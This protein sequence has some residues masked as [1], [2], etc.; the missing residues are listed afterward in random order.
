MPTGKHPDAT[1]D[2]AIVEAGGFF[3]CACLVGKPAAEVSSDG[4]YCQGCFDFLTAEAARL[5]ERKR[6]AWVPRAGRAPIPAYRD[7]Q[8]GDAFMAIPSGGGIP[9]C[10]KWGGGKVGRPTLNLPIDRILELAGQGL[11]SRA[12]ASRLKDEGHK[13]SFRTIARVLKQAQ[14]RQEDNDA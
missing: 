10:Q 4:H 1:R 2:R 7:R 3:C 12:I 13:V 6:P 8:D 14:P 9:S 11:G 5:P